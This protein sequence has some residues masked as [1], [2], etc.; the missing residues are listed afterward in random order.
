M[1]RVLVW[2]WSS[3]GG[4]SQFA[5]NLAIR[6]MNVLGRDA[7]T[8]S[9]RADDPT[10]ESAER[11]GARVLR[12]DVKSSR[13]QPLQ[14]LAHLAGSAATLEAHIASASADIV[15]LAMNFAVAAPLAL[16]LKKPLVYCAHDPVAH[17]GDFAALGQR[18][19]Q[20]LLLKRATRVVALSDFSGAELLRLGVAA[21]K[22]VV[23]PLTSVFEPTPP[24]P[25]HAPPRRLL[26]LGR[27]IAYKGIG[28]LIEAL[29][30]LDPSH[31]WEL[32]IAGD[33]PALD[34][35]LTAKITRLGRVTLRRGFMTEAETDALIDASDI[36][37][38]PYKSATQSGVASQALARGRPVLATPV[39]A[40]AEQLGHGA[41]GWLSERAEA[42]AFAACLA[43][44]LRDPAQHAIKAAGAYNLAQA[45]WRG[46]A[47]DWLKTFPD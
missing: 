40:L 14:S 21:Q 2:F 16:T 20:S 7:V 3:G 41:G 23:A 25:F 29:G 36:V 35:D 11:R 38:A 34:A 27:F 13:H 10:C 18:V 30:L 9:L 19:T 26:F 22:L 6:L 31:D 47:W 1:P 5:A 46:D 8:L 39:G 15:V 33:G 4:G 43:E 42:A 45:A 12:A 44:A 32:T 17:P 28:L 37:L 24:A